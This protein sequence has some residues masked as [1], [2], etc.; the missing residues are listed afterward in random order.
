M[1]VARLAEAAKGAALFDAR[2]EL[3]AASGLVS[4]H[5][6]PSS[7]P[8]GQLVRRRAH[9]GSVGV[10]TLYAPLVVQDRPVGTLAVSV[11][12]APAFA[13][14]R[15]AGLRLALILL[16]VMAGIV[17]IGAL[18]SRLILS[19]VRNL[20]HTHRGLGSGDLSARAEVTSRDELGELA[21]GVNDMADRL[22]ASYETLEL[23]VEQRTA[24]V[25]RLLRERNDLFTALSHDLRTPLA[26][27]RGQAKL[28][29]G[30]SLRRDAKALAESGRTVSS[31]ADQLLRLV[32]DILAL[33]QAEAG[34]L[35]LDLADL[36]LEDVMA[37]VQPTIR[38]LGAGAKVNVGVE[39]DK[40]LPLVR[41]DRGRL[42]EV[43]LN[44][45]DNAI[46]YTPSGGGVTLSAARANGHVAITV[47]DNGVGIPAEA[48]QR[49]FEPF[50]RV[51]GTDPQRG[52]PS[53]GIGLALA[54]RFVEAQ[55]GEISFV[56]TPGEGSAFTF[57]VPVA[58]HKKAKPATQRS[59]RA[60][61]KPR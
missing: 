43:V 47:A 7:A 48:G 2:G 12:S 35:D 41:A 42:R 22:Q 10:A 13:G 57:T 51:R 15:S 14:V 61:A 32:D 50:Y 55:G 45:A 56:S 29:A 49:V 26:V 52:Q 46:K 60:A 27:I 17:A 31:A 1:D 54:K 6:P 36:R 34:G 18:L 4:R 40:D 25:E 5:A 24:E 30:A 3:L 16:A 58:A 21:A 53:T 9:V 19:R 38:G 33:A 8:T 44:L 59:K 11:R 20:V 39:L 23:R 37:D 28:Q